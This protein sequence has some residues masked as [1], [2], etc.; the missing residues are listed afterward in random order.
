MCLGSC[1]EIPRWGESPS[2]ADSED[3]ALAVQSVAAPAGV[4]M[5][6]AGVD[7]AGDRGYRGA[8]ARGARCQE[9]DR[10]NLAIAAV[11]DRSFCARG[12]RRCRGIS[13]DLRRRAHRGCHTDICQRGRRC[14]CAPRP[15]PAE[16]KSVPATT[17]RGGSRRRYRR[18]GS[19]LGPELIVAPCRGLSVHVLVPGPHFLN[20]ALDL[21]NGRVGLVAP[22]DLCRADRCRDLR[23]VA[24]G[25]GDARRFPPSR[26]GRESRPIVARRHRRRRRRRRIQRLFLNAASHVPV[27]GRRRHV[28]PCLTMGGAHPVWF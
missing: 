21:I 9:N 7:D 11:A 28:C 2:V 19:P 14:R 27:A 15:E 1:W 23:G 20:G 24:T 3:A 13:G 17:F 25:I 22:I 18:G 4:E 10:R 6:R 16:C 5:D 12:R 8:A 26:P